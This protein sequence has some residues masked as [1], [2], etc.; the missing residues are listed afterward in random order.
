MI[1]REK[2]WAMIRTAAFARAYFRKVAYSKG[3][4]ALTFDRCHEECELR[5]VE[6][7]KQSLRLVTA[8]RRERECAGFRFTP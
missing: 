5:S 6:Q 1:T 3:Q 8:V 7:S 2:A 4:W